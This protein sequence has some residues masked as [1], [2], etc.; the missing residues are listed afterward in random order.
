MF[1][2]SQILNDVIAE[3]DPKHNIGKEENSFN[4]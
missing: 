2:F 3:V 1:L 4:Y